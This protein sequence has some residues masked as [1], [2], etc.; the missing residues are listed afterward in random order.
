VGVPWRVSSPGTH[1]LPG[2]T[3]R[4]ALVPVVLALA[5][6]AVMAALLATRS[7]DDPSPAPTGGGVPS[8][9]SAV[10][11]P[12]LAAAPRAPAPDAE[13]S[14]SPWWIEADVESL[15]PSL[16]VAR[17]E[18]H[19]WPT[20]PSPPY[21]GA[22]AV[23]ATEA[24][25]V[26]GRARVQVTGDG[27]P[28]WAV[29]F[30]VEG[31]RRRL[32]YPW[33][34]DPLNEVAAGRGR[35]PVVGRSVLV[36]GRS[37]QL[38]LL[39]REDSPLGGV[40]VDVHDP[41]TDLLQRAA[42]RPDGRVR[43]DALRAA[44]VRV[45]WRVEGSLRAGGPVAR[46]PR[47]WPERS[48]YPYADGAARPIRV[49]DGEVVLRVPRRALLRVRVR[50]AGAPEDAWLP[51]DTYALSTNRTG[52]NLATTANAASHGIYV[53]PGP[54][55]IS[56]QFGSVATP[57]LEADGEST[58]DLPTSLLPGHGWLDVGFDV[59][60]LPGDERVAC[61]VEARRLHESARWQGGQATAPHDRA[62]LLLTPGAYEVTGAVRVAGAVRF[63]AAR[64][65]E[66]RAGEGTSV[67]LATAP[68]GALRLA[69]PYRGRECEVVERALPAT[70]AVAV[71]TFRFV[72]VS[73]PQDT[74]TW[75]LPAGS[76]VLRQFDDDE[77]GSEQRRLPFE[78]REGAT[79][80]LV[81]GADG[82]FTRPPP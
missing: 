25:L 16:R 54:Y 76:Y 80:E 77:P 23:F 31:E 44:D 62:L 2:V 81:Q 67:M 8:P 13:P 39:D 65:V 79:T 11:G 52:R 22:A 19:W 49:E 64:S 74:T 78:T 61:A 55:R 14:P 28:G 9:P 72:H 29:L 50:V 66:V 35:G 75:W 21:V 4:R 3:I 58:V 68:A 47:P 6:L 56:T 59:R 43:F 26:E 71:S 34:A 41:E 30:V 5:A 42:T 63:S 33:F 51:I 46:P 40:E 70:G 15:D 36:G 27:R 17:I 53:E 45:A 57:E 18:A 24:V 32:A 48:G 37:L 69:G 82:W 73:W 7:D 1:R 10:A 60:A 20:K 12:G 38:R